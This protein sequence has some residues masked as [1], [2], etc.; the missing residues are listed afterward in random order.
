MKFKPGN[1]KNRAKEIQGLPGYSDR[2][3]IYY[4]HI[5]NTYVSYSMTIRPISSV[6]NCH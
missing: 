6:M 2:Y 5:Y 4:L 1:S 3:S